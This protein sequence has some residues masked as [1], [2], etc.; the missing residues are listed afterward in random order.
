MLTTLSM[1]EPLIVK[2][3]YFGNQYIYSS[4]NKHEGISEIRAKQELDRQ[5]ILCCASVIDRL[6][7]YS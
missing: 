7:E 2:N 3:L 6:E 5:F 1:P 4:Y